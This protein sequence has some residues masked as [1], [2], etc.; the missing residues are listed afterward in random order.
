MPM[1][2]RIPILTY[3]SLHAPG[4]DYSSNDH[5]ALEQDLKTIRLHGFTPLPLSKIANW[6]DSSRHHD[7][8]G[9]R[10]VGISFDDG[11]DHDFVDFS[12]PGIDTLHSF[13][14]ILHTNNQANPGETTASATSFVIASPQARSI[15]DKECIAGRDQWRDEWWKSAQDTGLITIANHSWDHTHACLGF[16]AQQSQQKGNFYCIDN[17]HAAD[18]QILQ[19]EWYIK[20]QLDNQSSGL[21]AYPYGHHNPFLVDDYF[22]HHKNTFNAAFTTGG[23]YVTQETNR[24]CIPRFVCGEHWQQSDQLEAILLQALC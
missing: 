8:L 14:T 16:V 15:L 11:C 12:Y 5:I 9:T 6:L 24:W 18:M 17:F 7:L 10:Y 23:E 21:F 22:P 19:A 20:H 2:L 3:H 4:N 13:Y 1:T